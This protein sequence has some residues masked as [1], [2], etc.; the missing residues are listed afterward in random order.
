MSTSASATRV[1]WSSA[2]HPVPAGESVTFCYE[3]AERGSRTWLVTP[4][5]GPLAIYTIQDRAALLGRSP[6]WTAD[7]LSGSVRLMQEIARLEREV[8]ALLTSFAHEELLVVDGYLVSVCPGVDIPFV[9]R[10]PR[11]RAVAQ[12]QTRDEALSELRDAMSEYL[13]YATE[14]G[15]VPPRD[16]DA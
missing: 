13:A 3:A 1:E 6:A 2:I 4:P 15:D 12:G 10:C 11:L 8:E 9:A 14:A 16:V 5:E 7:A